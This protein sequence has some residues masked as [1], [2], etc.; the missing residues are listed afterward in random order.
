MKI[1]DSSY[2]AQYITNLR[3]ILNNGADEL[4][5]RTG[6]LTR[7]V[8]STS[9]CVDLS[10]ELPILQTK[11]INW[12]TCVDEVLWIFQKQ[13]NNV[14]DLGHKIWDAWADK[15]GSIGK[16]YGYQ[17]AQPVGTKSRVFGSQVDY[18]L[19][20]LAKDPSSRQCVIDLWN[21]VDLAEMNLP[22]CV[23]SSIW[24]VVD[25]RLHCL[26]VQRSADYPVGVPFDTLEYAILTHMFARHLG[27][28]PGIL[29]HAISDSHIY[30]NQIVGVQQQI[31][32]FDGNH[33]DRPKPVLRFKDDAPTNFWTL[34]SE[35]IVIEDY[36]PMGPIKFNVA[37]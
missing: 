19:G 7:R 29:S 13:S 28:K 1:Q 22:P 18:V 24:T 33:E 25:G 6:Q 31:A 16:T 36:E 8:P 15:D 10:S 12:K 20:T 11:K 4:N 23:Y 21:P 35:D 14:K 30:A 32:R 26:V 34:T 17:V 27:L 5:K 2:E 3:Y 9:F 37:V